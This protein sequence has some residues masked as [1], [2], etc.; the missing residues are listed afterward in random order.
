MFFFLKCLNFR[1]V[2]NGEKGDRTRSFGIIALA[3]ILY[4]SNKNNLG[5]FGA[6]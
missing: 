5:P 2:K 4:H 3:Q 1:S 6:N